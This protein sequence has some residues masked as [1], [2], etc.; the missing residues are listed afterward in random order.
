MNERELGKEITKVLNEG[1]MET[2]KSSTLYRLQSARLAA[3][4]QCQ[5]ES[6]RIMNSGH[7]TSVY[8]RHGFNVYAGKL[9][10]LTILFI[11][12]NIVFSQLVDHEKYSVIDAMILADDLPV[13]A[14]I[15][16]E[17]EQ[18]LDID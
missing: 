12:M 16:N 2:I 3:L 13:D 11:F 8:G 1:T 4:E 10:V 9:L 14:Y 18:W 6:S 17:F 15:D 7:A 5:S